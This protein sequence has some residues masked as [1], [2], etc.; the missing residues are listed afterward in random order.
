MPFNFL[1]QCEFDEWGE[2]STCS[3]D[4]GGGV[5]TRTRKIKQQEDFGGAPCEGNTTETGPCALDECG[6]AYLKSIV[7]MPNK[8]KFI[9]TILKL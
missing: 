4:C 2:W 3:H 1:V 9:L 7:Y 6:M 5:K 8:L